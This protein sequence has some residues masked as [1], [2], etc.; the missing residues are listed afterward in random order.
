MSPSLKKP[1]PLIP[2]DT[3]AVMAPASCFDRDAFMIGVRRIESWGFKVRYREDIF[4][5]ARYLAGDDERRFSELREFLFDPEVKAI[6]AARGGYGSM[7]LLPLLDSLP[8]DLPPKIILGYSDL[9]SLLMYFYQ[10]WGWVTFH[11]PVVAKDIGHRLKPD[12]EAALLKALTQ[13]IPL[14]LVSSPEA[15]TLHA[16]KVSGTL[17]G[18]CLSLLVCSLGT[19]YQLQTEG[20][21]LFLED[22]GEKLYS[23]D[24]MITH[25]RL[26]G[27][28]QGVRGI[29]FG[30]L[31]DTHDDSSV[32][33]EVLSDLLRDLDI[34]MLFGIPSGHTENSLTLPFGLEITLDADARQVIFT[35]NALRSKSTSI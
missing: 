16:G 26:A 12:G 19:P 20:K 24:R 17:V 15:K 10:R 4:A 23:L 2:G 35:E 13:P 33:C 27:A 28:M 8:Q 9:T 30:P 29:I 6:F 7:R 32:I 18:G 31:K 22:V 14:G 5:K 11:G 1:Y 3:I 34:P 25:L 21:I